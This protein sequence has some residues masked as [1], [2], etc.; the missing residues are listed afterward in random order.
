MKITFENAERYCFIQYDVL[1]TSKNKRE[2]VSIIN[3]LIQEQWNLFLLTNTYYQ[4]P[5]PISLYL[6]LRTLAIIIAS[7]ILRKLGIF[8]DNRQ[9][10]RSGLISR[11]KQ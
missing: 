4:Y 1:F 6:L 9:Q 10:L 2:K 7:N 11:R 3:F 5:Y 8:I